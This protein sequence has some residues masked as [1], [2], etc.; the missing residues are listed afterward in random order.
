MRELGHD[1]LTSTARATAPLRE[2]PPDQLPREKFERQ[3]LA[4]LSDAEL[5]ALL[6]GSGVRGL[7]VI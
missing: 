1:S 4:A 6:F 7:N 2:L 3:G 5:L